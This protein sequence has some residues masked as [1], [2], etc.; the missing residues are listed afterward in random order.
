MLAW[1][2]F[3]LTLWMLLS[4]FQNWFYAF[5]ID[6]LAGIVAYIISSQQFRFIKAEILAIVLF[7]RLNVL[8]FWIRNHLAV[9]L[10]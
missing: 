1:I 2:L 7:Q 3:L 4:I 9:M 10:L 8:S 5:G 6:L